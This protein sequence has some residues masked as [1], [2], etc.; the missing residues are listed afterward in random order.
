MHSGVHTYWRGGYEPELTR[1]IMDVIKPGMTCYDCGANAGYFTLLFSK[2][3]GPGGRVFAF[4]PLPKNAHHIRR[5][6]E[7][8]KCANVSVL[9]VAL[10]GQ[11]GTA[12]F[13]SDASK[14]HLGNDG[15][16][17]VECRNIDSLGLPAPDVMKIDVEGAEL[18]LIE[19]AMTTIRH[20]RPVIFMSLHIEIQ[21]ARQLA[22][23]LRAMGYRVTFS[24]SSYDLVAVS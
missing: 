18:S 8:N 14:S 4:E 16:I 6:V 12:R 10:A 11:T 23:L 5:H 3:V 22:D 13:H 20:Y 17:T 7:M 2:L 24:E 15:D 1:A 9:E 21:S 19:G